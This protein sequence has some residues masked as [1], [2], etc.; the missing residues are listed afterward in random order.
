MNKEK[1]LQAG[2][3]AFLEYHKA[4]FTNPE[5]PHKYAPPFTGEP[6]VIAASFTPEDNPVEVTFVLR[7]G[8]KFTHREPEPGQ[9]AVR[10][11]APPA[12]ESVEEKAKTAKG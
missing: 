4:N 9:K 7:S 3:A 12:G 6:D 5:P 11:K 10:S 1:L 8:H 2:I